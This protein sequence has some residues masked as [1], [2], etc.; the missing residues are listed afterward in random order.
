MAR[1]CDGKEHKII[2]TVRVEPSIAEQILIDYG[3]FTAFINEMLEIN[4]Y[5]EKPYKKAS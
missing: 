2:K 5:I 1:T 4:G 3:S